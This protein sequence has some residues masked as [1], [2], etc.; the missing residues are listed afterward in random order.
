[1]SPLFRHSEENVILKTKTGTGLLVECDG[2]RGGL[3]RCERSDL[4]PSSRNNY[5]SPRQK[6]HSWRLPSAWVAPRV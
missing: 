4:Q 2:V 1:M 3:E 6:S 5:R